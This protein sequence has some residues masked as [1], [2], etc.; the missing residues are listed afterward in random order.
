MVDDTFEGVMERTRHFEAT[1]QPA[2]QISGMF[3]VAGRQQDRS[4]Y[5][6]YYDYEYSTT[7]FVS[8]AFALLVIRVMF[9]MTDS[10]EEPEAMK[11]I[12]F[13]ALQTYLF[14]CFFLWKTSYRREFYFYFIK[15]SF[16]YLFYTK[17]YPMVHLLL[18]SC[19]LA[20][21]MLNRALWFV[22]NLSF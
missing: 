9:A 19:T 22:I 15:T 6:V 1:Y 14:G 2:Y 3:G 20:I 21:C 7:L 12:A 17:A 11:V 13:L 16:L 5:R 8:V 18:P 10:F 4:H